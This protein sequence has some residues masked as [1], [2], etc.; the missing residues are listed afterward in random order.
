MINHARFLQLTGSPTLFG[1]SG[2]VTWRFFAHIPACCQRGVEGVELG[3]VDRQLVAPSHLK[4][5]ADKHTGISGWQSDAGILAT[6]LLI[7]LTLD[8]DQADMPS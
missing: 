4:C 5:H 8:G 3:N 2:F 6:L 1:S 7:Q